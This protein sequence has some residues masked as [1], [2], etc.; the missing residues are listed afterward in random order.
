MRPNSN[1]RANDGGVAPPNVGPS[2]QLRS[3]QVLTRFLLRMILLSALA[4]VGNLGF[5]KS[6]E[7]LLALTALYCVFVAAGRREQPFGPA[8]THF[9]EAAAYALIAGLASW[10]A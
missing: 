2:P 6:L 4:G 7:G 10:L 1:V 3:V 8:L 9:D 5:G